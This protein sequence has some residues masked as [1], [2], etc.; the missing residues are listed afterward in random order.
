M[1]ALPRRQWRGN[2]G[3]VVMLTVKVE[4]PPEIE[5]LSAI[6]KASAYRG[7]TRALNGIRT[8]ISS[9]VR[10]K[11]NVSKAEVDKRIKVKGPS[12]YQNLSG[13]VSVVAKDE[14]RS[15]LPLILFGASSRMTVGQ[16]N[17]RMLQKKGIMSSERMKRSGQQGVAFRVLKSGGKGFRTDAQIIKGGGSSWQAVRFIRGAKGKKRIKELRVLSIADMVGGKHGVLDQV[18]TSA[19]E[20]LLKNYQD[21]LAYYAANPGKI[22]KRAGSVDL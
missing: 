12:D 17:V 8:D 18:K 9:I 7:I 22:S 2:T 21:A 6:G 16:V 14:Q 3:A 1:S 10:S 11:Y 5:A 13:E 19:Q 20:R 4:I 15:N